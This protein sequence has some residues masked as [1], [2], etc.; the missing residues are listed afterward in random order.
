MDSRSRVL[1]TLRGEEVDRIPFTIYDVLMPRGELW[2]ELRRMGLTP[3]TSVSVFYEKWLNVKIRRIVEGDYVYTYYDTPVGSVYAKHRVNLKPGLGDSWTIEH[4]IKKPEDYKVVNYIFKNTVITP[5]RE[6]DVLKQIE[7]F[8]DE[9]V[10]WA[11]VDRTPIQKMLI[12]LTG[13]RR[14]AIDLYRNR[15]LLEEL[16]D[17]LVDRTELI[18]EIASESPMELVWCGDNVNGIVLGSKVFEKYHLPVYRHMSKLFEKN[19]KTFIVHMDGK[20]NCLKHLLSNSG[21][22]VVEAFTPPPMG[23]LSVREARNLWGEKIKIWIN[24]PESILISDEEHVKRY[25]LN[26][27][28]EI[29]LQRGILLGIT[30]DIAPGHEDKLKIVA[31]ALSAGIC[32]TY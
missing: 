1:A 14:L 32:K 3:I 4:P 9:R 8:K 25:T 16:Y 2:D 6:E 20:I 21:I 27:L 29:S 26:L 23:D 31:K 5:V 7:R 19:G 30:E 11:W 17:T 12:E 22:N 24:F 13:Y 10:F 28:E 15:E 18:C